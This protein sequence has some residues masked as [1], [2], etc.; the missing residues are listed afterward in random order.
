MAN[1]LKYTIKKDRC[2]DVGS[3]AREQG[4][5]IV[6]TIGVWISEKN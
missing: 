2:G 6:S 4:E 3:R 1:N 5:K